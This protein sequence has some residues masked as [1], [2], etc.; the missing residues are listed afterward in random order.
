MSRGSVTSNSSAKNS[1]PYALKIIL[2]PSYMCSVTAICFILDSVN[3]RTLPTQLKHKT[4]SNQRTGYSEDLTWCQQVFPKTPRVAVKCSE[5]K[6]KPH[7]GLFERE[8]TS[9]AGQSRI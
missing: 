8:R 5:H 4:S 2:H 7:K 9:D 3:Q 6:I 1:L